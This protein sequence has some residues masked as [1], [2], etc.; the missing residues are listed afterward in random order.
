MSPGDESNFVPTVESVD[1]RV[2][3][4]RAVHEAK[5]AQLNRE[6]AAKTN[7]GSVRPFFLIPKP[8]WNGEMGT[9]LLRRLQM[10]S[11][12]DWNVAFLPTD[13]RTADI[14]GVPMHPNCDVIPEFVA[15]AETFIRHAMARSDAI[16]AEVER[17]H[18]FARFK[19]QSDDIKDKV[20]AFAAHLL[21]QLTEVWIHAGAK[22][23]AA[24]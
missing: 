10:F 18:Q 12:E 6:V 14:L 5:L 16:H 21:A 8:C 17:T 1:A 24:N 4:D 15:A 2:A 11:Y 9:F 13:E 23:T 19:E 22:R 3:R 7:G 20:R